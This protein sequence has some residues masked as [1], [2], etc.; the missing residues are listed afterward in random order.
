MFCQFSGPTIVAGDFN[1]KIPRQREP[2]YVADA[3]R[4]TFEPLKI[5]TAGPL[6]P[7]NTFALDHVAHTPDLVCSKVECWP[8]RDDDGLK[9]SDHFGL[10]VTF[11]SQ[12]G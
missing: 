5:A 4:R 9:L 1:Q 6:P 7:L 10:Q 8:G 2:V 3:L 11:T 12:T